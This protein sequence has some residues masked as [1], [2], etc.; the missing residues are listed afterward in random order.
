M[1]HCFDSILGTEYSFDCLKKNNKSIYLREYIQSRAA[2][3]TT[4]LLKNIPSEDRLNEVHLFKL[5]VYANS[6]KIIGKR[7]TTNECKHFPLNLELLTWR[8]QHYSNKFRRQIGQVLDSILQ[9]RYCLL[10]YKSAINF[11]PSYL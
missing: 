2:K 5:S 4:P 3:G 9:V 1:I 10:S 7:F 8:Q 6:L 11:R